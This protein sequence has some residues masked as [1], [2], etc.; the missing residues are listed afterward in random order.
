MSASA[1]DPSSASAPAEAALAMWA[2]DDVPGAHAIGSPDWDV[3]VVGNISD[4]PIAAPE[5]GIEQYGALGS[6]GVPLRQGG[7]QNQPALNLE[8]LAPG[9]LFAVIVPA[10]GIDPATGEPTLANDSVRVSVGGQSRRFDRV[11]PSG[12]AGLAS[13]GGSG[14]ETGPILLAADGSV[15]EPEPPPAL[16][17]A[18]WVGAALALAMA[19]TARR[20][21]RV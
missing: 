14:L 2:L 6:F 8:T 20:S 15:L 17:I 7:Y 13:A 21:L 1:L 16:P 12:F 11:S 5:F 18:P 10:L 9:E 4:V 3:I 19:A